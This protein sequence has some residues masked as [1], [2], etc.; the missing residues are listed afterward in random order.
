MNPTNIWLITGA[1]SGIGAALARSVADNGALL[2]LT[3][4]RAV[5]LEAV[6]TDVRN[7]GAEAVVLPCDLEDANATHSMMDAVLERA[8]PNVVVHNAGRGHCASIEDIPEETWRSMF[9]LNVDPVFRVTQRCLPAMRQR[10]TGHFVTIASIAGRMA[11]PFNAAYVAAKHAVTGFTAALRTELAG[12]DIYASILCPAGVST[13][14]AAVTD[15]EPL[16]A[17]FGDGIR[18]SRSIAKELGIPT[19][20]LTAMVS[21]QVVADTIIDTVRRGRSSDVFTHAGTLEQAALAVSDRNALDDA[22]L[23]LHL[24]MSVAYSNRHPSQK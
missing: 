22:F 19:A 10:G 16:G 2:F 9:A 8:T 13:D 20:P 11:F 4:R 15:G 1:S 3:A 17:I 7:A 21:A 5:E 23:S 14:W 6:A 18:A 24:G 12:T